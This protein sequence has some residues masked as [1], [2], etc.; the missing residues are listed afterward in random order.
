ETYLAFLPAIFG[1]SDGQRLFLERFLTLHESVLGGVECAIDELPRLFDPACAPD[2]ADSWL[3]W[4][5]G[6]LDFERSEAW[7]ESEARDR[8][9]NAFALSGRRG[10][11]DG[12]R[13]YLR[14]Y[15][16]VE[17]R[18]EEGPDPARYW[19]LGAGSTLGFRTMLAPGPLGGAL[20][21]ASA[22]LDESL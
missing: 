2:D 8:L 7:A 18:I 22:T 3:T 20:L 1:R 4:L 16:G 12:L 9:A 13:D 21:G 15:A 14:M 17:S 19:V 5:S 6:W 10:T 11:I